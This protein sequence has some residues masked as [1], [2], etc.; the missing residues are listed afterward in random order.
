MAAVTAGRGTPMGDAGKRRETSGKSA[1]PKRRV[2]LHLYLYLTGVVV[3]VAGFAGAAAVYLSAPDDQGGDLG[4]GFEDY[5][6]SAFKYDRLGG[7]V[8]VVMVEIVQW[9]GGLWHGKQLAETLAFLSIGIALVCF[10][11]A[12]RLAFRAPG[13]DTDDH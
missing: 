6:A 13:D 11:V 10:V 4:A 7:R 8:F 1:T 5:K 3:L 9:L 12:H 2:R